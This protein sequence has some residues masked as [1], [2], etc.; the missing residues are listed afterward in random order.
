MLMQAIKA[1]FWPVPKPAPKPPT[2]PQLSLITP[3][4]ASLPLRRVWVVHQ[5]GIAMGSGWSLAEAR[6]D[7][8]SRGH[9]YDDLD[10][11][12]ARAWALNLPA[13]E[14]WIQPTNIHLIRTLLG[15][16]LDDVVRCA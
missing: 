6:H 16:E 1:M 12:T 4:G 10:E 2:P 5:R 13:A 8:A 7:A 9:H 11:A 3:I 14:L 15:L